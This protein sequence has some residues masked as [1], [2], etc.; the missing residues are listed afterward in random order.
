MAEFGIRTRTPPNLA[1]TAV[2]T[3]LGEEQHQPRRWPRSRALA[4]VGL[5]ATAALAAL[6]PAGPRKVASLRVPIEPDVEPRAVSA[7]PARGS[8]AGG[9]PNY[10]QSKGVGWSTTPSP[11]TLATCANDVWLFNR[12][13]HSAGPSCRTVVG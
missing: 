13:A 2:P 6:R 12:F 5:A 10:S 11:R 1:E 7:A 9:T 4:A 8:P 3:K